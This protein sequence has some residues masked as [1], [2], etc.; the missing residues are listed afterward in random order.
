[1]GS[2]PWRRSIHAGRR[3]PDAAP[4]RTA[5]R[6]VAAQPAQTLL[7]LPSAASVRRSAGAPHRSQAAIPRPTSA[8]REPFNRAEIR[9][10][11]ITA[12]AKSTLFVSVNTV[13]SVL[14]LTLVGRA[15]MVADMDAI[16]SESTRDRLRHNDLWSDDGVR[17]LAAI[18]A[19]EAEMR[20]LR[21]ERAS[22]AAAE[23]E[24]TEMG[25]ELRRALWLVAPDI[26]KVSVELRP[27]AATEEPVKFARLVASAAHDLVGKVWRAATGDTHEGPASVEALLAAVS[28]LRAIIEGRTTPPTDEEIAAHAATGGRWAVSTRDGSAD[29]VTL[30]RA[31]H[32]LRDERAPRYAPKRWV[33]LDTDCRPCAWPIVEVSR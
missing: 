27:D 15:A 26:A 10:S 23:A 31:V 9:A 7:S 25:A 5:S 8:P 28:R 17:L 33:A 13:G 11:R 3:S 16:I 30:P 20:Q 4:L 2:A 29:L 14:V 22:R 6:S 12:Q 21:D 24:R 18:E 32:L 1:M 19:A